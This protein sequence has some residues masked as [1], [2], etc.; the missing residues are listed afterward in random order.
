MMTKMV[1]HGWLMLIGHNGIYN[2]GQP[3]TYWLNTVTNS[4]RS[5]P[6]R[7]EYLPQPI[8]PHRGQV[9][10]SHWDGDSFNSLSL[11][12]LDGNIRQQTLLLLVFLSF[13]DSSWAYLMA[14]LHSCRPIIPTLT[15]IH[16]VAT[17][18]ERHVRPF[19]R[20]RCHD[21][22]GH[23][24]RGNICWSRSQE[25]LLPTIDPLHNLAVWHLPCHLHHFSMTLQC[26]HDHC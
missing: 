8:E 6:S 7:G 15:L 26:H 25:N 1:N 10:L 17:G 5:N 4:N 14:Y 11:S 20:R 2:P 18:H 9:V 3:S 24:M 23:R 16:S 21:A 12:R 13:W 22:S 19:K